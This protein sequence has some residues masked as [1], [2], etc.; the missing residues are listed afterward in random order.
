MNTHSA[1]AARPILASSLLPPGSEDDDRSTSSSEDEDGWRLASEIYGDEGSKKPAAAIVSAGRVLGISSLILS[2]DPGKKAPNGREYVQEWVDELS[3][4]LL[5]STITRNTTANRPRAFI[6]QFRGCRPLSSSFLQGFIR[7]KMPELS[8]EE[9]E[10]I[11]RDVNVFQAFEFGQIQGAVDQVSDLLFKIEQEQQRA[12]K[13]PG[14]S[15]SAR[16]DDRDSTTQ[17]ENRPRKRDP[18]EPPILLLIEGIDVAIQETI[19]SSDMDTAGDRLCSFLRTLTLLCRTYKS[20]LAVIIANSITL[21]PEIPKAIQMAP[22][23]LRTQVRNGLTPAETALTTPYRLEDM[24]F[25]VESVFEPPDDRRLISG[26]PYPSGLP[27]FHF[28]DELDEGIDVHLVV[29]SV[30]NE[31]VVEIVKDREGNNLGR[32]DIF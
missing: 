7:E 2:I 20:L 5:I 28:A 17:S 8:L 19:R 21:R 9:I 3:L 1:V 24:S 15:T 12:D 25:P 30:D 10:S 16:L 18:F 23:E 6:I 26:S 31:R 32:W 14:V 4:H 13:K 29:S 11:L 27:L 22:D